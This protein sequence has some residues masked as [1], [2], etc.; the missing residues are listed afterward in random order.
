MGGDVHVDDQWDR[1]RSHL[2]VATHHARRGEDHVGFVDQVRHATGLAA[3][4]HTSMESCRSVAS[5]VLARVTSKRVS[6]TWASCQAR[7]AGPAMD[8]VTGSK[9]R[10]STRVA[11][12]QCGWDATDRPV[13]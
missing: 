13:T 7:M 5:T 11:M 8:S 12:G 6:S 10:T 9:L 3:T 4:E 1:A 2:G